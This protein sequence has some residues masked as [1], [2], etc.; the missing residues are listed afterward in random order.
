MTKTKVIIDTD[1]GDD[2]DDALALALAF[3]SPELDIIGITTVFRN[4][5]SRVK[6]A[7]RLLQIFGRSD[8]PVIKG[9]EKPLIN[10]WDRTLVPPQAKALEEEIEVDEKI[11]AIDFIIENV[12]NSAERVLLVPIGPLTNIATVLIKEP[13]LKDKTEI[14]MMGGMY[15][16]AF[17]EWN[18]HCDPE[19]ARIVF[20]SGIPITMVGLDV[21]LKCRLNKAEVDRIYAFGS[22]K[23]RFLSTLIK[24]W[25]EGNERK[26]PILHDPLVIAMLV[27]PSLVKT[28]KMSIR[29]ETRGEF[30]RGVTVVANDPFLE[31]ESSGSVDVCVEVEARRFID[32]FLERVLT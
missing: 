7:K 15:S 20:D 22:E 26:Y 25:Q 31:D 6:L 27:D 23:T 18:I 5:T 14:Y 3:N 4:T 16:Q 21:T 8:I 12:L 32:L 13:R 9:I 24:I 30:T 1:I 11:S 10:D 29:V 28:R 19:A 17:P 2:V